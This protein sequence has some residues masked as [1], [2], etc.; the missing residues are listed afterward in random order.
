M[1]GIIRVGGCQKKAFHF[2]AKH[3][4]IRPKVAHF[5]HLIVSY[6]HVKCSHSGL[7]CTLA[8]SC[9]R[10]WVI[11]ATATVRRKNLSNQFCLKTAKPVKQLIAGGHS[12]KVTG[13]H[14]G[15][16]SPKSFLC[17]P[18][19]LLCSETLILNVWWKQ[20]PF[21][22]LTYFAPQIL[23]PNYGPGSA[24]ILSAIKIIC[25]EGHSA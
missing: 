9:Q 5:T 23:K 7:N 8:T 1:R 21:P 19:I 2:E 13:G 11:G 12:G 22:P 25:F 24:K 4:T 10:Y 18:Q 15:K 3:P 20:K 17:L 6:F 16:V 14:S